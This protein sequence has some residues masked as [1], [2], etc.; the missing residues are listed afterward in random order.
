MIC[1]PVVETFPGV[2][3]FQPAFR[4][5][6]APARQR[7]REAR[8]PVGDGRALLEVHYELIHR[9]LRRLGRQFGLPAH[10]AEELGSWALLKLVEDDYRILSSWSGRSS[11]GTFLTVVLANLARDYRIHLWGKWRPSAE[12]RRGGPAAVALERLWLRDG[13]SLEDAI[14]RTRTEVEEP[15]SHAELERIAARLPRRTG[16]RRVDEEELEGIPVDGRVEAGLEGQ[17]RAGLADR[18][19]EVLRALLQELPDADRL[20]LCLHFRDGLTLAA[21]APLFGTPQRALYGRRDRCLRRLRAGLERVGLGGLPA[22]EIDD[23]SLWA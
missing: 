20:L 5:R 22:L 8:P 10:E 7:V 3:A 12:A 16:R 18:V 13:L 4:V 11:F 15:P 23:P 6:S 19:R 14:S 17:E 9:R 21:I 1:E 2:P